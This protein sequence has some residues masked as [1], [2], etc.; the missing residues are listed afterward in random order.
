[1]QIKVKKFN[2]LYGLIMAVKPKWGVRNWDY[3][4]QPL[5]VANNVLKAESTD[6]FHLNLINSNRY[7]I[8]FSL[9]LMPL[10]S[11]YFC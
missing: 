6:F 4:S 5:Q 10:T 9:F 8:I 3:V 1:M 11:D 7:R 2:L